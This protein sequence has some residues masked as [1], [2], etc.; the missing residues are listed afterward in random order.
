MTDYCV[1]YDVPDRRVRLN[2]RIRGKKSAEDAVR[3]LLSRPTLKAMLE[4][5]ELDLDD[6]AKVT[7]ATTERDVRFGDVVESAD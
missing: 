7:T 4:E 1:L 5:G 3:E 2:D 6:T